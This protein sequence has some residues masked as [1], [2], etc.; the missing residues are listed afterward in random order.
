MKRAILASVLALAGLL[1]AANSASAQVVYYSSGY[2][3]YV[4]GN[5]PA[6]Y[7]GNTVYSAPASGYYPSYSGGVVTSGYTT[8]YYSPGVVSSGYYSP[9]VVS[10]S[11]YTPGYT[12]SSG[13]TFPYTYG[14][15]YT[16]YY[17]GYYNRGGWGGGRRW[18]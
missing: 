9:G 18:R 1:T 4:Y 12:Y 6:T 17:G 11:Y 14:S 16:P 15:G 2:T 3:P 13:Y 8:N 5:Y 7:Y 10:S